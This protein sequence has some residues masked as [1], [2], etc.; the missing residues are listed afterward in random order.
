MGNKKNKDNSKENSTSLLPLDPLNNRAEHFYLFMEKVLR[1][2]IFYQ[3]NFILDGFQ[4][5]CSEK[6]MMHQKAG[7]YYI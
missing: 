5:S 6:Y 3:A 1:L 4:Y 2:A 7:L